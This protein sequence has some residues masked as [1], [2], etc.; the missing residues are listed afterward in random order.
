MIWLLYFPINIIVM[1]ICY[2][3]NPIVCLFCN[4]EGELPKI[5]RMWQTWDDSCNPA[6]FIKEHVPNF[7]KYDYDK[8]Y[9]EYWETTED[10]QQVGRK[11]CFARVI[12]PNFTLKEKIQRYICRV[13]WLTRNCAYGFAF[14]CF[15]FKIENEN[16]VS[17]INTE[18]SHFCYDKSRNILIRPW[19]YQNENKITDTIAWNIYIGWKFNKTDSNTARQ[20]MIANRIFAFHIG[21]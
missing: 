8:H 1:L 11:R 6:F 18:T 7:L 12:N 14:W 20:C 15:G 2:I 5:F 19:S 17:K 21:K 4:E 3:T 10:L 13:L 16:I 9:E